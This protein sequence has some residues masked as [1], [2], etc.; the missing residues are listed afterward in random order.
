MVPKVFS[1]AAKNRQEFRRGQVCG[2]VRF[3][4]HKTLG[5]LEFTFKLKVLR[6]TSRVYDLH[7]FGK[8]KINHIN[9]ILSICLFPNKHILRT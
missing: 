9:V 2:L 1:G 6:K 7:D 3:N 4:V 8:F 5:T